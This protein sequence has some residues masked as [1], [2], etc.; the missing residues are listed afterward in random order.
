MDSIQG[1]R[2][3]PSPQGRPLEYAVARSYARATLM[4]TLEHTQRS[5]CFLRGTLEDR[6]HVDCGLLVP[7]ITNNLEG[8]A[9]QTGLYSHRA[10]MPIT[11][12]Q[13][14]NPST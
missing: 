1:M 2:P 13:V 5:Q 14:C 12:V 9:G 6:D 8:Q 7:Q 3:P 11:M 10:Q 4:Y